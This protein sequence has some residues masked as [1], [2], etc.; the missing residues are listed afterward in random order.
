MHCKWFYYKMHK[1]KFYSRIYTRS[2]F[3]KKNTLEIRQA[4]E[5]L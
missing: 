4:E 5:R 2:D 3:T 1:E